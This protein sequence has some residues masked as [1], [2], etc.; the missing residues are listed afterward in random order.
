M[1]E[2]TG[3]EVTKI[4]GEDKMIYSKDLATINFMPFCVTQNL[5]NAYSIVCNHFICE[6]KGEPISETDESRNIRWIEI[7]ELS[8]LLKNNRS[9][10]FTMNVNAIEK[11]LKL[12]D[13]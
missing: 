7:S 6:A 12:N 5:K 3:L 10:F 4:L 13:L 1:L 9:K 11:Y 8:K 2:E